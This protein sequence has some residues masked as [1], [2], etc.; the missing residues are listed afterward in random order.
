MKQ[1]KWYSKI[2]IITFIA[3]S[4]PFQ[5]LAAKDNFT[6]SA[7]AAFAVDYETG[8]ILY[9]QNGDEPLG[10]A[11]MTKLIT[12]YIVFDEV[13]KGNIA[14][15][16]TIKIS[17]TLKKM[18]KNPDLSNIP[19]EDKHVYTVKEALYG[20]LI[21]S[22]NSLT[23]ALAEH[24][25]GTEIK[26]VDRMYDQLKIWGITDASLV[27]ASGLGNEDMGKTIYPGSG[28]K[29]E[30][31]MSARSMAIVGQH[32]ITDFPEVLEI[33][34]LPSTTILKNSTKDGIEIWNS[35][36]MLDG[37]YYYME[38]VDGLKTGTTP[39][40]GDCFIGTATRNG[41]RIITVVMGTEEGFN[42]FEETGKLM[43]Y[44]YD[45]WSYEVI[46]KK[47]APAD[48]KTIDVH[49]GKEKTADIIL[50]EDL[51]V[52]TNKE[53][54]DIKLFFETTKKQVTRKQKV[55]APKDKGY[56]VGKEYVYNTKDTLGYLTTEDEKLDVVDVVLKNDIKKENIFM[57]GW[58]WLTRS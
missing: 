40:A 8:K 51:A 18:S 22:A 33:T 20:S 16:D 53:D 36:G 10:I 3:F 1:T 43:T 11:S 23:S 34:S 31:M 9:N 55:A 48:K 14:W 12:A 4:L 42:R 39:L 50:A 45:N 26:F 57:Q 38:G 30:N 27:T 19:I 2:I 44:I 35:N 13:N 49:H 46:K 7:N 24:I 5:T 56:V 47:G 52:W 28:K 58:H 29:D 54:K 25:S 21:S 37:F 41:H 32:L 17:D 6:V 15:D